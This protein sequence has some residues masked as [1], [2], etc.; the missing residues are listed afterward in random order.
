MALFWVI[1]KEWRNNNKEK[2]G[3]VIDYASI[4]ELIRLANLES[5]NSVFINE[6][7]SQSERLDRL[8]KIAISQMK[9]LVECNTKYIENN[10]V[11]ARN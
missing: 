10:K 3:N 5:L 2:N 11:Y 1:V 7:L 8:N 4:D 6:G 9:I